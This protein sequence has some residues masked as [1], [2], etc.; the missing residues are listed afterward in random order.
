LDALSRRRIVQRMPALPSGTVT[1]L[2]TDIEG[3]TRLLQDL[4]EAYEQL[5]TDHRRLLHEAIDRHS[6]VVVDMQGDAFF[7]AFARARDAVAAAV[8][9]QRAVAAHDWPA[10]AQL[11]V[12]MAIHTGEPGRLGE[13]FVGESVHRAA[14]ICAA[15]HG[16]QILLSSTTRDLVAG[17]L[18]P[19]VVAIDLGEH[20]LKDIDR[21]E[22]VSQLVAEGLAPV[23]TPL[24]SVQTQPEEATPFAGR[25][26]E[27]AEAAKSA[28]A[29]ARD[30]P[31][32][33]RLRRAAERARAVDWR[34]V[35]PLPSR[36]RIADRVEELGLSIH[37]AA[38]IATDAALEAEL[39]DLGRTFVVA[40]R[41]ARGAAELLHREDRR[42]LAQK[43]AR[44]RERTLWDE[45]LVAADATARQIAAL[46]ALEAANREFERQTRRIERTVR[47]LRTRVF[48]TR[49]DSGAQDE[50]VTETRRVRDL[51]SDVAQTLHA[52]HRA[53]LEASGTAAGLR[54]R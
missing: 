3:S 51:T 53:A 45:Q 30:E 10:A 6:G 18:P 34:H 24:K 29:G 26:R 41:D 19:G 43:L 21:P 54:R 47:A 12:R 33:D 36:S 4:G 31:V 48:D 22:R 2:F 46:K 50:L 25:E 20:R 17:Q 39:R 9:A 52:A 42:A 7:L 49:H 8:D 1:L 13:G 44:Y 32:H 14:R 38:R 15:G 16:G 5:L 28:V 35:V 27:L 40:A 37:A 23:L 11:R